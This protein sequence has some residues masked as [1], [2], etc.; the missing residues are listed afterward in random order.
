MYRAKEK[1]RGTHVFF[2]EAM[3]R[4]AQR[5]LA[6]D[7]ELRRAL[8]EEQFV[9]HYQPQLDLRANR[10]VG[11]EA[12]LRWVHPE[13]GL[14]APGAVHQFRRGDRPDRAH[15]RVGAR[16]RVRPVHRLAG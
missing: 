2:E 12:L 15:R 6:L 11:A 14:V 8:E 13:R 9:L 3:N 1:G 10:I 5:R 4:E 16:R 7:R